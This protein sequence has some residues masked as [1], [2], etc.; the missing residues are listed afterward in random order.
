MCDYRQQQAQEEEQLWI[1]FELDK[2]RK[3]G[4]PETVLE[5]EAKSMGLDSAELPKIFKVA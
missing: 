1:L 3:E 2:Q 5:Q 4:V